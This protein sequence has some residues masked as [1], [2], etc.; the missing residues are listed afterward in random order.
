MY[1]CVLSSFAFES[2]APQPREFVCKISESYL[3]GDV[4]DGGSCGVRPAITNALGTVEQG[5]YLG[6]TAVAHRNLKE[7]GGC[8]SGHQRQADDLLVELLHGVQILTRSAIS[9]RPRIDL[10]FSLA[11]NAVII[12]L[13]SSENHTLIRIPSL[14]GLVLF[15]WVALLI[16]SYLSDFG[17]AMSVAL[18][19]GAF[20]TVEENQKG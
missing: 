11:T 7:R 3:D 15:T 16:S 2:H 14:A 20:S 19:S 12:D 10:R 18:K 8:V 6:V 5:E 13:P 17:A 9:P 4:V 1:P